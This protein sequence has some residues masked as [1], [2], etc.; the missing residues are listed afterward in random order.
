MPT[1]VKGKYLQKIQETEIDG[2]VWAHAHWKT[3]TQNYRRA[4]HFD[5]IAAWLAPF[6]LE[7][8][9][10]YLSPLNR[11]LI[12]AVCVYLEIETAITNSGDYALIKCQTER[13]VD[14]CIQAGCT[15]YVS[16]PAARITVTSKC[17]RIVEGSTLTQPGT[18]P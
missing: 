17:S 14:L 3:L 12:E 13:L 6:Y 4:P 15:D 11:R 7:G 10:R 16:G 5:E 8:S 18:M 2:A 9:Y 1:L